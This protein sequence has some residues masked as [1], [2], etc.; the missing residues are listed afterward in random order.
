MHLYV[1]SAAIPLSYWAW[2]PHR[3][4]TGTSLTPSMWFIGRTPSEAFSLLFLIEMFDLFN[5]ALKWSMSSYAA[6]K[7]VL[8]CK[9]KHVAAA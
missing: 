2:W 3:A 6:G 8:G 5:I 1:A 9:V 7:I 4:A